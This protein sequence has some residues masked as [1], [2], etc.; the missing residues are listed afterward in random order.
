M[1]EGQRMRVGIVGA[2]NIAK[3][4]LTY[5][6]QAGH[7]ARLWSPSGRSLAAFQGQDVLRVSGA[8]Q[9]EFPLRRARDAAELALAQVIVLALPANGHRMAMDALLPHL[10]AQH[11]VIFSGHLSFA[12]LYL[13]R[14]LAERGLEIPLIAWNTTAMTC[15]APDAPHIRIGALRPRVDMAVIPAGQAEAALATCRTLFGDRFRLKADLLE[16]ALSNLNPQVHLAMVLC[17]LTRIERAETWHQNSMVT[18]GVGRLMAALDAER[19]AIAAGFGKALAPQ[20]DPAS[21][22][23]SVEALYQ[24]RVAAGTDPLGPKSAD[25]RYVTEDVPFGLVPTVALARIAGVPAPLHESAIALI[26]ACYGCDF[27]AQ[28]DILDDVELPKGH[29]QFVVS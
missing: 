22:H 27:A 17:N 13:A 21:G 26:D 7:D 29:C 16:I 5:L 6:T 3:A 9:G 28:N 2:G 11:T 4:Y 24:S 8:L 10:T 19:L 23:A 14:R 1:K 15:K 18:E 12:C 20:L 25:T